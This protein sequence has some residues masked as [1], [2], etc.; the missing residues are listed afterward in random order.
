MHLRTVPQGNEEV[1]YY[2]PLVKCCP[3]RDININ[4][5]TTLASVRSL[6]TSIF[7]NSFVNAYTMI[8]EMGQD[9][10]NP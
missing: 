8:I 1:N 6:H 5:T 3:H 9:H 4:I 2:T 10:P 7:D